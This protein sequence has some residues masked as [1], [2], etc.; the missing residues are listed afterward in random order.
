GAGR[1]RPDGPD[2]GRGD[3]PGTAVSAPGARPRGGLGVR[4]GEHGGVRPSDRPEGPARPAHPLAGDGEAQPPPAV[5]RP[6]SQDDLA[7]AGA[8]AKLAANLEALRLLRRLQADGRTANPAEQAVLAR[9]SG[10]G[11]L[12]DIFDPDS[13][14]HPAARDEIARL[15]NETE[16]AAARR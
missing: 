8:S 14:S 9:W 7:P 4:R 15:L 10:W 5:F 13:T 1:R 12:P 2:A 3:S 11:A 16:W 6:R